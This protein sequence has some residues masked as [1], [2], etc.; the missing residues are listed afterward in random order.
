MQLP[1]YFL[2][3]LHLGCEHPHAIADREARA[4]A[5]LRS[6]TGAASHVV[7]V[8]DI[9]EFW[10]EYRDYINRHHF[11]LLRALAELVES[12]VEVH[13][14]AGN[15]D[16]LLEDFFPRTLG[17]QVHRTLTLELQGHRI[18]IQHG[19]G[20][21]R[22][23]WKYRFAR[24]ILHCPLNVWLFRLLHPDWGMSLARWVGRTSRQANQYK[25]P[26]LSEY[27]EWARYTLLREHCTAIIHGHNHHGG[28]EVLPEGIHANCGQ[29]LFTLSY[30]ELRNGK[31]TWIPLEAPHV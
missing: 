3:D 25:D 8:G 2:S 31:F 17:V 24:R 4:I 22:S 30:L 12:G 23:D 29:W 13:Y 1:A 16:F 11:P 10:M 6:W 19:D 15:H 9:F 21:A 5:L 7:L 14:L 27:Q 20:T 28:V 26:L 18:W